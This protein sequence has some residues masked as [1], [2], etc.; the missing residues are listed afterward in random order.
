MDQTSK[1]PSL[2]VIQGDG[3]PSVEQLVGARN[4]NGKRVLLVGMGKGGIA[5]GCL[6]ALSA[7][8]AQIAV[9]FIN[10]KVLDSCSTLIDECD[11]NAPVR[12]ICDVSKEEDVDAMFTSLR[13]KGWDSIDAVIF[14]VAGAPKDAIKLPLYEASYEDM[15]FALKISA[16]PIT[17]IAKNCRS[18]MPNGGT[19]LSM[20]YLGEDQVVD[21]Y[22]FMG[23]VKAFLKNAIMSLA[24][25]LGPLGIRCHDVSPGPISTRAAS[26]LPG[27]DTLKQNSEK[28][29]MLAGQHVDI[30]DIGQSVAFL[31]SDGAR[32]MTAN[33]VYID[34]GAHARSI[35]Q[36]DTSVTQT[37]SKIAVNG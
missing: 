16:F 18:M 23:A 9:S 28:Q 35:I 19:I 37:P 7:F 5:Q 14:S 30:Y 33:T 27:F 17:R 12:L 22:H 15:T 2:T 3:I 24:A 13:N 4:L 26:G 31:I 20:G 25:E 36:E 21:G 34:L 10:Q 29:G 11:W 1:T 6:A 8:G 32:H